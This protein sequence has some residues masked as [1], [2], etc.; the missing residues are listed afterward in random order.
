LCLI[1][2]TG[3]LVS[4]LYNNEYVAILAA[5]FVVSSLVS[6]RLF[7]HTEVTLVWKRLRGLMASLL[8]PR[9][10]REARE[11]EIRLQGSVNWKEIWSGLT[12]YAEQM[13]L[14]S[15]QLDVNAPF[16]GEG[17][18]ARWDSWLGIEVEDALWRTEIPLLAHARTIG[19]VQ[20]IGERDAVC[21]SEKVA[22]VAQMV[23]EIETEILALSAREV[24]GAGKKKHHIP[25]RKHLAN[26]KQ[27]GDVDPAG[28]LILN[29]S[30]T[31][32]CS[33]PSRS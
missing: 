31:P 24:A 7:G 11:V 27:V 10:R 3:A 14:R 4:C 30:G 20:V 17:Y 9:S 15:I 5:T 25:M 18:H 12:A 21:V 2:A 29:G 23:K 28:H 6:A 32:S 13:H 33:E 8:R 22:V 19:R 16:I 1:A 26:G